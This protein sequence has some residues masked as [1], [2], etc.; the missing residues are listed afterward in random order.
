[1]DGSNWSDSSRT[2]S[3]ERDSSHTADESCHSRDQV[4]SLLAS[5]EALGLSQSS[6]ASIGETS[7]N[8]ESTSTFTH[9]RRSFGS[10]RPEVTLVRMSLE[11]DR[12]AK[13]AEAMGKSLRQEFESLDLFGRDEEIALLR[14]ILN[15]VTDTSQKEMVLLHGPSGTGKTALVDSLAKTMKHNGNGVLVRGKYDLERSKGQPLTGLALACNELCLEFLEEG[16]QKLCEEVAQELREN[17]DAPLL[18]LLGAMIPLLPLLLAETPSSS[19]VIIEDLSS[20]HRSETEEITT[21]SLDPD[22]ATSVAEDLSESTT[23]KGKV[24]FLKRVKPKEEAIKVE[25]DPSSSSSR[26]YC[27]RST[28]GASKPL[29]QFSMRTFLRVVS[30]KLHE[31]GSVVALVLD[32]MVS[33]TTDITF[34]RESWD[35][36][37]PAVSDTISPVL[38]LFYDSNGLT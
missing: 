30:S 36:F 16:H 22:P 4:P 6:C 37:R 32:D 13:L 9:N 25:D 38:L 5:R 12:E 18:K 19:E 8:H 27:Q 11:L 34:A 35:F 33:S 20:S 7:S 23:S 1:M 28:Q 14:D 21:S 3:T 17:I 2:I 10:V 24:G 26:S 31:A 29:L 15:R